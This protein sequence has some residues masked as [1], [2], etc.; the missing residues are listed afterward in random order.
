ME[1]L[2]LGNNRIQKISDGSFSGLE[3]AADLNLNF[4]DIESLNDYVF[5]GLSSLEHLV[6]Q[7][8]NISY[9]SPFA[10]KELD[11][12][13]TLNLKQNRLTKFPTK[14]LRVLTS[15][16]TLFVG[17]NPILSLDRGFLK[18]LRSLK[19][20]WLEECLIESVAKRA[21]N[22]KDI[23]TLV[24]EGNRLT[25]LPNL[26]RME[27]LR[28]LNLD[29]NPWRCDRNALSMLTWLH[30]HD[31]MDVTVTCASP[32]NR[33]NRNL[34]TFSAEELV[35][36]ETKNALKFST[37]SSGLSADKNVLFDK[38][39]QSSTPDRLRAFPMHT[40]TILGLLS[41]TA[42]ARFT[43]LIPATLSSYLLYNKAS[44]TSF[45]RDS[46]NLEQTNKREIN[47]SSLSRAV[48]TTTE[49]LRMSDK[50][51]TPVKRIGFSVVM[52]MVITIVII[53][54]AIVYLL[55]RKIIVKCYHSRDGLAPRRAGR[56]P[57]HRNRKELVSIH[58]P[59]L[60]CGLTRQPNGKKRKS[61]LFYRSLANGKDDI[62]VDRDPTDGNCNDEQLASSSN[63]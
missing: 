16:S 58:D 11:K 62:A 12:L 36:T 13:K 19:D 43:K 51:A 21:F 9:I 55:T 22:D 15:V 7:Q 14:S 20:L 29:R 3:H 46:V 44:T 8:N 54:L 63:V 18:G 59:R 2:N 35:Q 28:V 39:Y 45:H 10:F 17:K 49:A 40:P 30:R 24:L 41:S 1:N 61:E 38:K 57:F 27:Q 5:R 48:G 50:D 6:L 31:L 47:V 56:K 33:K 4:N 34:L 37:T 42:E 53:S 23:R 25:S 60:G 32:K 52:V 26:G